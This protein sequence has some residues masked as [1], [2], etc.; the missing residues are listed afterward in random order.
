MTDAA[1]REQTGT[2]AGAQLP[3]L[4][5][6]FSA[7]ATLPAAA[8]GR[9]AKVV[10][11]KLAL[12]LLL[13]CGLAL[14]AYADT[15]RDSFSGSLEQADSRGVRGWAVD[16][17]RPGATIE[18]Q[19]F[20]DGRFV[21]AALADKPRADATGDGASHGFVFN[22]DPPLEGEHEARIYAVRASRG[23]SRLTLRQVGA[24]RAFADR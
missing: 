8:R 5:V 10:A 19:L 9:L 11:A 18:V 24:P 16:E 3:G 17:S 13:V 4:R 22:F 14:Y 12:D 21:A 15:F 7:R 20:V 23:G 6:P 1:A 2:E